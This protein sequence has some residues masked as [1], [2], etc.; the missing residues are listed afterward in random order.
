MLFKFE[1]N[2]NNLKLNAYSKSSTKM[3]FLLFCNNH[4]HFFFFIIF[5]NTF[6]FIN[7]LLS[8]QAVVEKYR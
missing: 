1:F 5:F 2:F 3:Y 6:I 7:V 8:L 4:I